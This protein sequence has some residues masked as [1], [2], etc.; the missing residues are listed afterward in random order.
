M[1]PQS[2]RHLRL[3]IFSQTF[4]HFA[5]TKWVY[6]YMYICYIYIASTINSEKL[7]TSSTEIVISI[8]T[9]SSISQR[10]HS[11]LL[12]PEGRKDPVPLQELRCVRIHHQVLTLTPAQNSASKLIPLFCSQTSARRFIKVSNS[13]KRVQSTNRIQSHTAIY[14]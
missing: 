12:F 1:Y 8:T 11:F 2:E 9:V 6:T 14:F 13:R 10:G 5:F 7:E 4:Y 3:W